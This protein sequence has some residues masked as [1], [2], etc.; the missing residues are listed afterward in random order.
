MFAQVYRPLPPDRNTNAVNKYIISY[1]IISYHKQDRHCTHKRN[2]DA[3]S[4]THCCSW[5]A[6]G[7]TYSVRIYSRS[8]PA[9]K[10]LAPCYVYCR[11]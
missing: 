10:A 8:Y 5:K 1:H 7:I 3:H 6:N 9:G 11:L 2:I 4:L